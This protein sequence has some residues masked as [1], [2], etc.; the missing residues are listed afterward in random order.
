MVPSGICTWPWLQYSCT[1]CPFVLGTCQ[2]N[3]CYSS[4]LF[5]LQA[6]D[7]SNN[8][9]SFAFKSVFCALSSLEL[10]RISNNKIF[11]VDRIA[12]NARHTLREG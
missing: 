4:H 5:S 7:L 10:L 8:E 9:L 2:T 12:F 11:F 1:T 6:L 3:G